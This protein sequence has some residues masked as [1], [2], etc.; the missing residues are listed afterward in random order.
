[1]DNEREEGSTKI[2]LDQVIEKF[3]DHYTTGEQLEDP[4]KES[5]PTKRPYFLRR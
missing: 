1:M 5:E 2:E 3:H 4:S